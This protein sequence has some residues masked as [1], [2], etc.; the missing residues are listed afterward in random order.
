MYI[1][2]LHFS[3]PRTRKGWRDSSVVDKT[4]YC[5]LNYLHFP[6]H[7]HFCEKKLYVLP[8]IVNNTTYTKFWK[9]LCVGGFTYWCQNYIQFFKDSKSKTLET[10]ITPFSFSSLLSSKQLKLK[11]LGILSIYSSIILI[12]SVNLSMVFFY[13]FCKKEIFIQPPRESR[14]HHRPIKVWGTQNF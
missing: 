2:T 11:K 1:C 4:T 12:F 10:S 6:W 14:E 9:L 7:C 5:R 3:R 13:K 8:P